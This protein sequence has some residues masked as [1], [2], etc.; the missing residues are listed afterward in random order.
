MA[1][2]SI[3]AARFQSAYQQAVPSVGSHKHGHQ[4]QSLATLGGAGSNAPS[5]TSTMDKIGRKL[6]LIA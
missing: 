4:G 3:A 6:D 2:S 1:L 5:A